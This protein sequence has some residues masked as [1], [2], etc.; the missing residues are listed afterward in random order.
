MLSIT[1][2]NEKLRYF[3]PQTYPDFTGYF[4]DAHIP[5]LSSLWYSDMSDRVY[6]KE[7]F[8]LNTYYIVDLES[9]L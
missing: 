9:V 7:I 8:G 5:N 3:S 6:V 1:F 2:L 4:Y